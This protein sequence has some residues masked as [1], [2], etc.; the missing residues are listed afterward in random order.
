MGEEEETGD[1]RDDGVTAVEAVVERGT[2]T[3][4][5]TVETAKD[6]KRFVVERKAAEVCGTIEMFVAET[7][8]AEVETTRKEDDVTVENDSTSSR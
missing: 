7:K 4:R 2:L 1:G 3:V 6:A 5:D 8:A